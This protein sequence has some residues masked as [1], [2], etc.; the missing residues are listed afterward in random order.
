MTKILVPKNILIIFFLMPVI[1]STPST[2]GASLIVNPTRVF[3]DK[4]QKSGIITVTNEED[5]SIRIQINAM[6]W[7]QDSN[8]KDIY[9]EAKDLIF[10]PKILILK[11]KEKR[12]IRVGIKVPAIKRE[13]TYRL[14]IEEIPGP[15]KEETRGTQIT[16][17]IRFGV[18]VFV[19]PV[20]RDVR[21]EIERLDFAE[22]KLNLLIKNTGN[23][24]FLIRSIRVSGMGEA[25]KETF[26]NERAG[27]YIL[28]EISK[29]FTI[30][31]SYEVCKR[32]DTIN[33][34]VN[35][36]KLTL[37]GKLDVNKEMCRQ[38]L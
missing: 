8:G 10:F 17:A 2:F 29:A 19:E 27:W 31:I 22:G 15:E 12:I 4:N 25:D 7:T 9:S 28:S 14:Y 30:D 21:G 16:I 13:K 1:F 6:E 3:F 5:E 32:T 18:P 38:K 35:T 20:K 11:K 37:T 36:D 24:H 26:S 23:V 34:E 33:L